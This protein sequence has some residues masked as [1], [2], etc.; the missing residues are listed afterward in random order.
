MV[1]H[2]RRSM[3]AAK[4]AATAAKVR[5]EHD[6]DY[7]GL[8]LAV[9]NSFDVMIS[10]PDVKL[11]TTDANDQTHVS[12]MWDVYLDSL[13]GER[14]V[15]DCHAC[16]NFIERY[17]HLV[18]ISQHGTLIPVMWDATRVPEFYGNTFL[19]LHDRVRKAHITGLFLSKEKVWGTP[20]TGTWSHLA[21]D[22]PSRL[23]HSR[24]DLTP[25]QAMAAMRENVET[26]KTA[27][28]EFSTGLLDE[29]IRVLSSDILSRSEKFLNPV[30][31]LR[32]LH[33]R[34]RNQQ[35]ARHN[36]LWKAVAN[37]PEGYCHPRASVVGSLLED[38]A[39]GLPF[40]DVKK[41]F[42]AKL[43][44]LRYQR[45]QVAPAAGTIRAAEQ[46]FDKMGLALSL[47][48]RFA[49]VGDIPHRECLWQ[50]DK[51]SNQKP[52]GSGTFGHIRPKATAPSPSSLVHLPPQ[53]MTWEK[54]S[55]TVL[56]DADEI[57]LMTPHHNQNGRFIALT[58]AVNADALP[59]LKWD[60]PHRRN[61]VAWYVYPKG[62][63][64]SQ[65][66]LPASAWVR[67]SMVAP[68]PNCW[69]QDAMPELASGVIL[70]IQGAVD[71]TA[72]AGNALFPECLKA[73]LH[74]VRS[75]IEAY[76]NSAVLSGRSH[77]LTHACG[78]DLRKEDASCRL[79]VLTHGHWNEYKIDRWD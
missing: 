34:S 70:V 29:A 79:R 69:G 33:D 1:N 62:S 48:R 75:V 56:P 22:P 61:S 31:W 7:S 10:D 60:H 27:L 24:R 45:P 67:V 42:D 30:I 12:T 51:D 16:R 52:T 68:L 5:L 43:H 4:K 14:Q 2:P 57:E 41:K 28:S 63:P 20:R 6:H 47:R 21:V 35:G 36:S 55:R 18:T 73:E 9:R 77:M 49:V 23:V 65:W 15:H 3:S 59:I 50:S 11:F 32:N 71:S 53:V 26:V 8:L 58:A 64:A 54:F 25:H 37:A 74:G 44:P 66:G 19:R 40:A 46:L 72:N 17:G 39:A 76:S 38:L 13:P 78:Y